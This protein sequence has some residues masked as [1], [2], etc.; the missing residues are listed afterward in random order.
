MWKEERKR[1]RRE[2]ML[3]FISI[4]IP[5][6]RVFFHSA[7]FTSGIEFRLEFITEPAIKLSTK[8]PATDALRKYYLTLGHIVAVT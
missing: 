4:H 1:K 8:M 6:S 5:R 3:G 2:R 7:V